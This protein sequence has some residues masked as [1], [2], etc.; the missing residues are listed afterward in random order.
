MLTR[1]CRPRLGIQR[2]H[3][4]AQKLSLAASSAPGSGAFIICKAST[5]QSP[6]L[7]ILSA[8]RLY[9]TSACTNQA[10]DWKKQ[11]EMEAIAATKGRTS[12]HAG[13]SPATHM[14]DKLEHEF[15]GERVA[16][17]TNLTERLQQLIAKCHANAGNRAVYS[18]LRKKVSVYVCCCC[19]SVCR[20]VSHCYC[21][22][23]S[24]SRACALVI[25]FSLSTTISL[26]NADTNP[27][28]L[29]L[30]L[31]HSLTHSLTHCKALEVRAQLVVQREAGGL[32]TNQA[33][34]VAHVEAQFPIPPMQ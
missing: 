18:T 16:N 27:T 25:S 9:T 13:I 7:C 31:P 4:Q 21:L 17:A 2:A 14:I 30:T 1:H 5:R 28:S 24:L 15:Q 20:Y 29:S 34:N 11:A 26:S 6:T 3:G 12:V 22:S 19:V 32:A 10:L 23:L 8:N 33:A